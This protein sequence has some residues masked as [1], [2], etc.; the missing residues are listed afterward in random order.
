MNISFNL[1]I[2]KYYPFLLTIFLAYVLGSILF[3]FLPKTG[4]SYV[5]SNYLHL[6]YEKYSYAN[7]FGLE[8]TK[9]KNKEDTN[10]RNSYQDL[11]NFILKGLYSA[12]AKNGWVVLEDKDTKITHI[13]SLKENFQGYTL[14]KVF[15]NFAVFNK[16]NK[17]YR[18]QIYHKELDLGYFADIKNPDSSSNEIS[19]NENSVQIPRRYLN[20]YIKN[21]NKIWHNI[22]IAA[23]KKKGKINGFK[24]Y[25]IRRGSV[26][27]KI[28]LK[29][30]DIIKAVNN[31]EL[32]SYNDAFSVYKE[33]N[34]LS[35]V[36][37]KIIRKGEEKEINYEIN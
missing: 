2:K 6:K 14:N 19:V 13:V 11:D 20:T 34:N 16:N 4:V 5:G 32:K 17:K 29:R 24:I 8:K 12:S 25:N 15:E 9:Q 10:P 1:F 33:I 7:T 30:G 36:T 27:E 21:T 31:R 3:L 37:L 26:F 22:A 35:Y 28:G 23:I 18:L